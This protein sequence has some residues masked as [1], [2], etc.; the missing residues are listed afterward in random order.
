MTFIHADSQM[1]RGR[2]TLDTDSYM[3]M[4]AFRRFLAPDSRLTTVTI[5]TDNWHKCTDGAESLVAGARASVRPTLAVPL[6]LTWLCQ[7]SLALDRSFLFL[8]LSCRLGK[9]TDEFRMKPSL[10]KAQDIMKKIV[11]LRTRLV[12]SHVKDKVYTCNDSK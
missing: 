2:E 8:I 5:R 7:H 6:W 1:V 12:A 3:M 11:G 4:Y 9:L 10:R